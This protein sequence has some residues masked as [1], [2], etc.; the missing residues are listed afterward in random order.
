MYLP[1]TYA[2]ALFMLLV[3][4]ACWG[5][6]ANTFKL[7]KGY[8]FELFY[9]DYIVG[10]VLIA[11]VYAFTLGSSGTAGRPFLEDLGQAAPMK[12]GLALLSG[13]IF[14]VANLL[15]VAAIEIAGLAV[16]FPVGIGLALII[17]AV[18]N[19]LIRPQGN[20]LILF[21]GVA[22]VAVAIVFD[23]VAYRGLTSGAPVSRKGL[24]LSLLAG[25]LMGLFY[26][27][28]AVAT[29]GQHALGPYAAAVVFSLGAALCTFPING[30]YFMRRPLRGQP[31]SQRDYFR[32]RGAWHL[33]GIVGGAIWGT[34][35]AFNFVASSAGMVGPAASYALGQGATMVSAVWGV[36]VWREFRGAPPSAVRA[37]VAMFV[38]FLTG[39][40]LVAIAPLH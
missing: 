32:A 21:G 19:Y 35:A 40:A 39:L 27:F 15:L 31:V 9:W 4:M 16:A 34:G 33:L 12:L 11:V 24:A 23:A 26:P 8:R 30:L 18:G 28:F 22:L 2:V 37:L 25:V 36:F 5:S 20:A 29:A 3:S 10:I 17:G 6:W 14:N 38:C 7:A 1:P 13:I